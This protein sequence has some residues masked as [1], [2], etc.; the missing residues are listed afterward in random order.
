MGFFENFI[1]DLVFAAM[2][3]KKTLKIFAIF[4]GSVINLGS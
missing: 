4:I 3:L 1:F 2:V